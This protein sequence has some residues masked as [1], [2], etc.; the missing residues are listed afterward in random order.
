MRLHICLFVVL[1]T[2]TKINAQTVSI[3]SNP[4]TPSANIIVG[5]SNYNV[6]EAL[7]M[8]AEIGTNTFTTTGS[9]ISKI[10]VFLS[11][12][13]S[14]TLCNG[15]KIWMKNTTENSFAVATYSNAGYTLV[16]SGSINPSAVG[17]Y[18]IILNTSFKRIAGNNLQIMFERND[19]I[20]NSGATFDVSLG[21]NIS[22]STLTCRR[23]NGTSAISTSS[24]LSV[25]SFRPAIQL[26]CPAPFD[27]SV[28]GFVNPLTSCYSATQTLGI[29]IRNEGSNI[30]P[31]GAASVNLKI[32]GPNIFSGT[33]TNL[34]A[35]SPNNTETI[36]FT[37]INLNNAG[38]NK[39]TATVT[40][41]GDTI[42]SNNRLISSIVT[43]NIYNTLPVSEGAE[44]S[45]LN[46][47]PFSTMVSGQYNAWTF[48]NKISTTGAYN[49]GY[50][51]DSL[52][53][54]SGG[55]SNFF[56]FNSWENYAGTRSRIYSHCI[57]IPTV[58]IPRV[59]FWMSHDSAFAT[60]NDSLNVL[61]SNDKGATWSKIASFTRPNSTLTKYTWKL[62]SADLSLY[63][64]QTIQIG[65]EGLS[66][67]GNSFGLDDITVYAA[68]C[69]SS[70]TRTFITSCNSYTWPITG[71]TY[72]TSG[73]Y[74]RTYTNSCGTLSADTLKLTIN[75]STYTSTSITACNSFTWSANSTTYTT[76][77]TYIRTYSNTAGCS[78]ADTLKLT[79]YKSTY[80]AST[81]NACNSYTWVA[82]NST[83]YTSSGDYV[84]SYS[85]SAGC[86]SYDTLHLT[87]SNNVNTKFT[88]IA[89]GSY[90]WFGVTYTASGTYIRTNACGT[91]DTL[92]LTVNRLITP[93]FV[94]V[95]PICKDSSIV[96]PNISTN[97]IPGTWSPAINN[98][99]TTKYTFT[100]NAGYCA[101]Q[102][103]MTVTVYQPT[104]PLFTQVNPICIGGTFTLPNTSNNDITGVWTPAVNNQATTTYTFTP[105][106]AQCA[107]KV[108]MTVTVNS[109][110]VTPTFT[111]VPN[112]CKGG[113]FTLPLV[114]NNG[115]S[116]TWSPAINNQSTT[117]Y[118]FTP[119]AGQCA[120]TITMTVTVSQP[121]TPTFTQVA[122]ICKG[123]IFNLPTT[124][125]NGVVGT[126]SPALNNQQTITYTFTPNS[127][128]CS[129]TVTMTVTVNQ[130]IV[131]LFSA[132]NPIC[133]GGSFTLPATSNN[134]I[135]GTWTPA[136][137]N[138]Q[139]TTYTF[140]PNSGFCA[141]STTLTVVVNALRTPTFTQVA[142][143]C[144]GNNFSLPLVSNEGISG[145]W[146]PSIN[147]QSTTTYTFI[148]NSNQCV[149]NT[150]VTMTVV[151]N[152]PVVPSFNTIAPICTGDTLV[153]PATSTNGITG[154]WTPAINNQRTT[155]YTF[156]P[157]SGFCATTTTA[158]VTVNALK[159]PVFTQIAPVCKGG[160]IN[161]PS[162]SNDSISG[163]WSPAVNNQSTTTYTFIPNS[164]QCANTTTMTV[165]VN[166]TTSSFD[167]VYA[168]NNYIWNGQI[169]S[170]SGIYSINKVNVAGCDSIAYL[171]LTIKKASSSLTSATI[172]QGSSYV[173]N[174]NT[175]TS[176]GTYT[177]TLI[178]AASCDSFA[179]LNLTVNS[180]LTSAMLTI[181]GV[182][183]INKCDTL[184]YYSV[185]L[186]NNATYRWTVTGTGNYIKSGISSN[187]V[188]IVLKV[189]GTVS[190]VTTSSCNTTSITSSF[191]VIKSTPTTPGSVYQSFTPTI[192]AANTNTCLFNQDANRITNV[193]DTF[194]IRAVANTTGY[195]WK[196][197]VGSIMTRVNDTT[198][199]VVFS[200]TLTM[201]DSIKVYSLSACD[202]SIARALPLTKVIASSS[203]T[204][205]KSFNANSTTGP[206]AITNVCPLVGGGSETYMIRKISTASSYN[207]TL[208]YGTN[209]TI[210]HLAPLGFN[211]TAIRI[212]FNTGF[213][214][215]TLLLN[216]INGCG[217][218]TTIVKVPLNA[219]LAPP[220]PT[221]ITA[222]SGNYNPCIGNN[223]QYTVVNTT[224]T[225]SQAAVAVYRWTKPANTVI[226]YANA[227]S[228]VINLNI[229]TAYTG[230]T[231]SV[232]ASSACGIFS[233]IKSVSLTY[234]PPTPTSITSST[235][236]NNPCIGDVVQYTVV[237]P[238]ATSAQSPVVTLRW[239][240]PSKTAIVTAN[241][242]SSIISIRFDPLYAGGT[243][244]VRSQSACGVLGSAKSIVITNIPPAP[245]SI[246]S[247][248]GFYNACIGDTI[249]YTVVAPAPSSTQ[250][251]IVL[252]RWT[253]PA[254][255]Y[256]VSANTDS[257]I[258]SIRFDSLYAGGNLT[259][260]G[261]TVCGVLGTSKSQAL[262]HT[263]CAVG[264][265]NLY[266]KSEN[267]LQTIEVNVFPNPTTNSFSL[268]VNVANI[269]NNS[270]IAK[271]K[272]LDLQGRLVQSFNIDINRKIKI[273]EELKSGVYILE[274][275]YNDK[276][277]T[278]K[279][280]KL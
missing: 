31:I 72:T 209:A 163:I 22:T 222:S 98:Q 133:A 10:G 149:T 178:N 262:T 129:N 97:G 205:Y 210:T 84:R 167:T 214:K 266:V 41:T 180:V 270:K 169:Y 36:Y 231:L 201:P 122:P 223:F 183:N 8:D 250:S 64:G 174:G 45:T 1:M 279:L 138:Q 25:S 63:K 182:K 52:L 82:N 115:Y 116:G 160:T 254:K 33:A 157:N 173:F 243:L 257:S 114:S 248:T 153:L 55:G 177:V 104:I 16:Y 110:N 200:N 26:K 155:T 194:R 126:W 30:I 198:I 6:T 18:E 235:G 234:L 32:G 206:V 12:V 85:N 78:S 190:V 106:P 207:W 56:L 51:P 118:T 237:T 83:I 7:Y 13:G 120:N 264:A 218:N 19:G 90:N 144:K 27:A 42:S 125:N 239:T 60:K 232:K 146:T 226:T 203:G 148:P 136:I 255:T 135:T 168:C 208:K 143:I 54:R 245:T 9:E 277:S 193:A 29:T 189:A 170:F 62:D 162:I 38:T 176:A 46:L 113:A 150:I 217:A 166:Q 199:A 216:T 154:T 159:I 3:K 258:I 212:T 112:I 247:S 65:F 184:Q 88:Q 117:T 229:N 91:I 101:T 244:A 81:I 23:Y 164:G 95:T 17:L 50:S 71:L 141:T 152:Q 70:I 188:T 75:K 227:D 100:P 57:T 20:Y 40:L 240:I 195:Y 253:L 58:G 77:G 233:A 131:P 74:V 121:S 249:Q 213:T 87:I 128:F 196:L 268:L 271:V 241:A 109:T 187:L 171:N 142:P 107:A 43:A 53:P 280:I 220:T 192:V 273:G 236:N 69:P 79:I 151:V 272:L 185:P 134:S 93:T 256:V 219:T 105:D 61:V 47:I 73:T 103:T 127:T 259:V 68:S 39:D 44:T 265:R 94:Q 48:L 263:G 269:E 124:S 215:D 261:Q 242:D 267:Q 278:S 228:S 15:Y 139:T 224:P 34:T 158:T 145:T 274:L 59:S 21:N 140:T 221:N 132:I 5:Y 99:T 246:T 96:L 35:I 156:T 28:N 4:G 147:N 165:V 275:T 251:A 260:R 225:T 102:T 204:I 49:N 76:S 86:I 230:G 175:F 179:V 161:L 123:G 238:A 172:C 197:P 130:P 202:T 92:L 276:T 137:N 119:T 186:Y 11:T 67:Y 14:P 111:Q 211:D 181:T 89:C 108:T 37:G 80:T 24:N 2:I 191:S 66:A 252:F